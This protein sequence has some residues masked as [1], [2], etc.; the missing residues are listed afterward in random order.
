MGYYIHKEA[1]WATIYVKRQ[2]GLLHIYVRGKVGSF[3]TLLINCADLKG[4]SRNLNM[5]NAV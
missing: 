5:Y 2:G 1:R 3:L 4:H